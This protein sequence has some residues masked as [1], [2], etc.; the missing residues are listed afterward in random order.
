MTAEPIPVPIE[1][2]EG[3]PYIAGT[4]MK[5]RIIAE[6]TQLGYS[7]EEIQKAHP[8]LS[9]AQIH[10]ALFYY[11][12]HKAEIDAEIARL[13]ELE[14]RMRAEATQVVTREELQA[15]LQARRK[16]A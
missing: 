9:L 2:F 10:A 14:N 6:E 7:P 3:R 4:G 1:L 12:S 11:Y 8:N 5:V 16:P 15:R 13:I